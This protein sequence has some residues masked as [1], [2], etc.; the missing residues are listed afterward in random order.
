M[1]HTSRLQYLPVSVFAM[2]MGMDGFTIAW[3][4][5][6]AAFGLPSWIASVG[7]YFTA[8]LL[9]VLSLLYG[10]KWLRYPQAVVKEFR[11]PVALSF[12]PTF[13]IGVLLLSAASLAHW[14]AISR[15]LWIMG[16]TLHLAFTLYV[17]NAW[18][19]H[20]HFQIQH[21]NPAWFI[22]V[23]GNILVPIAGVAHG[24]HEISWF[25]FSIGLLYWLV[26]LT[27]IFYRVIFHQPLP[28]RLMPTLFILIAPPA[29][30]FIS[31]VKLVGGVDVF[32]RLLYYAALFVTLLLFT[33]LPRFARLRF[34]ISWW[35][36]S[37][38]LAA[39]TIATLEM[40]TQ[41]GL[42]GFSILGVLFLVVLSGVI[43]LLLVRTALA[44]WRREICVAEG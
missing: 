31:Y 6:A 37:F 14:P 2:V 17:M 32:A 27:I 4:R 15:P 24:F 43:S 35:A 42:P 30:G 13:S 1:N 3:D 10:T 44:V 40:R 22:P 38:P 20:E 29:V 26:L 12:F 19:H 28:E 18:L 16:A 33:Q 23:V 11:H 25:Y 36:Y 21:I 5:G 34:F 39:V 7:Y 8:T 41:L 9:V